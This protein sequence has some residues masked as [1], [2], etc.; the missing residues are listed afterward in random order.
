[1]NVIKRAC[2]YLIRKKG[3]MLFLL[4]LLLLMSLSIL[5]GISFKESTE[6]ELERLRQSMASGFI[7]KADV[8][9]EMYLKAGEYGRIF[10]IG[11]ND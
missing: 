3:R 8:E 1:M 4:I 2:I 10:V 7:L 11:I 6:R 5:V 9:N